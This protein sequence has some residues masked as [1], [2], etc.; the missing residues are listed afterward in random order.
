M[1]GIVTKTELDSAETM[2]RELKLCRGVVER[3][4]V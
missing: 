1:R 2:G 4:Q 3:Y